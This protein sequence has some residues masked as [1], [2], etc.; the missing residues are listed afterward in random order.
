MSPAERSHGVR[1][2]LCTTAVGMVEFQGL[3]AFQDLAW[4]KQVA[5]LDLLDHSRITAS[6]AD[7]SQF[8]NTK[9]ASGNLDT[10]S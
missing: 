3:V 9:E 5:D 4:I 1:F 10:K 7:P 8:Q 6:F 2:S